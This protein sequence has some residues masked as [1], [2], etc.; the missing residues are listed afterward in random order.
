MYFNKICQTDVYN[1]FVLLRRAEAIPWNNFAPVKD[2]GSTKDAALPGWNFSHII[3][4]YNFWRIHNTAGIPAKRDRIS[5][6]PTGICNHYLSQANCKQPSKWYIS[7]CITTECQKT[8]AD[9]LRSV[10]KQLVLGFQ[11][12]T[13][14]S[15]LN[16]LALSNNKNYR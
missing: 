16:P 1:F 3:A 7:N 5:S 11:I 13:Q 12:A 15:G 14:F 2:P 10:Y 9:T 4:R 8:K 6:R